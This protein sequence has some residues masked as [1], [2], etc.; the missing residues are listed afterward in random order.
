MTPLEI[1]LSNTVILG[2]LG[3]LLKVWIEKRLSYD[4][5]IQLEKFRAE[6]AKNITE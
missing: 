6:L 4:L 2:T 3:F 5:N 1:I